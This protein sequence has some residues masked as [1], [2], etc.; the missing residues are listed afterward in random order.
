MIDVGDYF[1]GLNSSYWASAPVVELAKLHN[2]AI[3]AEYNARRAR[4]KDIAQLSHSLMTEKLPEGLTMKDYEEF[5]SRQM[6]ELNSPQP[7]SADGSVVEGSV[8]PLQ[9]GKIYTSSLNSFCTYYI[10]I[11]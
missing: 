9:K 11:F 5:V 8:S 1:N 2:Q 3:N 6:G 10:S 4:E 7:S